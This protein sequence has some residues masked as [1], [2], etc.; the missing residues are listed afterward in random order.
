MILVEY[1]PA[2]WKRFHPY[3]WPWFYHLL[4]VLNEWYLAIYIQGACANAADVNMSEWSTIQTFWHHFV[5]CFQPIFVL[6]G[7]PCVSRRPFVNAPLNSKKNLI[8]QKSYSINETFPIA[9][10][11]QKWSTNVATWL[12]RLYFLSVCAWSDSIGHP[13]GGMRLWDW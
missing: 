7:T 13:G 4:V 6:S 8:Q 9:F 2:G 12:C 5:P 3:D 11:S 1:C 10:P